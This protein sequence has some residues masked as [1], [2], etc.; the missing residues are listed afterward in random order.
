MNDETALALRKIKD[1]DGNYIWN[2]N[3]DTILG[4]PVY[5]LEHMPGATSGNKPIAFGDFSYYWIINRR[6]LAVRT[7]A[8]KFA[9]ND[10]TGYLAVEYLDGRLVRRE[11]IKTLQIS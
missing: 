2:H 7:L 10:Q 4:K 1:A 5:I 11:A 8:E 3:T 6:P 9:L